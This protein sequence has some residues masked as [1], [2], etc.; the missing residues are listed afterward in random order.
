MTEP[1]EAL[2][3][4][5]LEPDA[6]DHCMALSTEAGWNQTE[7]DWRLM[8][9]LGDGVGLFLGDATPVATAIALPFGDRFAWISMVL[10]S[11]QYRHRGLA[12]RLMENRLTYCEN[13][14]LPAMLDA[15]D[16]GRPIYAALGFRDLWRIVRLEASDFSGLDMK[17]NAGIV[18]RP[19]SAD[20]LDRIS[21]SDAASLGA[22]RAKVLCHLYERKPDRAFVA[23]VNGKPSGFVLARDGRLAL[24]VGPLI[25]DHDATAIAL[26]ARA[27]AGIKGRVFVDAVDR[28]DSAF[29]SW[30]YA[31]A[32]AVQRPFTRMRREPGSRERRG[33][34]DGAGGFFVVAGPEL[35]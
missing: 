18:V 7:A 2:R 33:D 21:R 11:K 27:M 10:V 12:T 35:G 5:R 17:Q 13:M 23:E 6:A 22:N 16:A 20:D 15:T 8:L 28:P 1:T 32:F 31:H 26:A 34:S 9:T 14:G 3:L 30:L 25:A 19:I 24:H 29:T 4:R